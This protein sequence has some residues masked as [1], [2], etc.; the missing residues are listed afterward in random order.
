MVLR[1]AANDPTA[2]V[3]WQLLSARAQ[4]LVHLGRV[5]EAIAAVQE[6]LG[7]APANPQ[8][9]YEASLVYVLAGDRASALF[10]AKR[11]LELGIEPRWF[12][13]PWFDP[14]R[15]SPELRPF[16]VGNGAARFR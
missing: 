12:T 2:S 7:L 9:A 14:L 11:S 8:L 3:S 16:L 1:L 15:A 6:A 13:F 10:N 5:G 4:A